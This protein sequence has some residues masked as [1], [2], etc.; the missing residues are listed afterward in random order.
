MSSNRSIRSIMEA[1]YG[2]KCMMEEAGIRFIPVEERRKIKGYRKTDEAIT[3]HHLRPRCKGGPATEENGALLKGYNHQWLEKQSKTTRER[4]N[5]QLRQYKA[6][7]VKMSIP[8]QPNKGEYVE[9]E[10]CDYELQAQ[11]FEDNLRE[12]RY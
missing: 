4:I 2:K 8:K 3:Y 12:M 11:I 6:D 1:K 10:A 5:R 9:I 7:F